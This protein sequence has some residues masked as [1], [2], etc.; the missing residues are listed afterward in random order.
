MQHESKRESASDSITEPAQMSSRI[1]SRCSVGLDFNAD[2]PAIAEFDE[3][4]HFMPAV[5][6]ADMEQVGRKLAHRALGSQL[7][8]DETVEQPAQ[9]VAVTEDGPGIHAEQRPGERGVDQVPFRQPD[10]P[11]QAIG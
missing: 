7:R 6:I 8:H 3:Y 1:R 4:V 9:Q 5:R 2:Y 10:E 11:V